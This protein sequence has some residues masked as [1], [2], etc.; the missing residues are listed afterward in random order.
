M[1]L[2]AKQVDPFLPS[3]SPLIAFTAIH[4]DSQRNQMTIDLLTRP[5]ESGCHEMYHKHHTHGA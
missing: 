4:S 1:G 3:V 5:I 2:L